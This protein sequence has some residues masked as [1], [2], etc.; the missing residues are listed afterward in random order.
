MCFP[1]LLSAAIDTVYLEGA[2]SGSDAIPIGIAE[3]QGDAGILS[4]LSEPPAGTLYRDLSLSG[5]FI[6]DRQ[7]KYDAEAWNSHGAAYFI[8]GQIRD[9]GD[10]K[11]HLECRLSAV[12]SLDLVIG[13]TYTVA[14]K[15]IRRAIHD[16]SDKVIWQLWGE[17]GAASTWLSYV[18][19]RGG[20]KQI[21]VSDYDGY[22]AWQV[23]SGNSIHTM[24]SWVKGN[25]QLCYVSFAP[26]RAEIIRHNLADGKTQRLFP[27]TQGFSPS[28]SP[29]GSQILFTVSS[30]GSS[31]IYK[32]SING[33][34]PER[35]TFH[36]AV[37]TSPA[38][39]PNGR[40]VVYTSDRGGSPQ[41]YVM[42]R[43]GAD[44]RRIT[45]MG[46]YNE[47][48]AWSPEGD[49]IAYVSMD[50]GKFNIYTCN[51]DGSE[52]T[53]LTTEAGNNESPTWSPDG[54]M[55]AFSSTRSGSP[56]IYIMRKD[57]TGVTKITNRG[58]NTL[59]AWSGWIQKKGENNE[60]D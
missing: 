39:S 43:I 25:A 28:V 54:R 13:N 27:G 8:H 50:D 11:V 22:G 17:Q 2:A 5:R 19:V 6:P 9:A 57:G 29:D 16:F 44:Q 35:M 12:Q 38:W 18:S 20:A 32:G 3:F 15:D 14:L 36:W 56:Q 42:D 40:E 1:A 34:K 45:Y 46:R 26:G 59:P 7:E 49:R 37:E 58:K 31:D 41:I 52:V 47:S 10:G 48:A 23:T 33:G 24:P 21:M 55:I 60:N 53:Q 4:S 30:G 51:L